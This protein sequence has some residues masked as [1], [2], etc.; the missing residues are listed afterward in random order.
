MIIA[1]I[2][3]A[4]RGERLGAGRPKAFVEVA[5][6]PMFQWSVDAMSGVDGMDRIVLALPPGTRAP[7][8]VIAVDGGA[9]RSDSVRR[10]LAAVEPEG[11]GDVV[12]VHDAARPLVTGELIE[13]VLG[14]LAGDP[15]LDAAIA[16][17][18]VADT[19]KR[20][21][22]APSPPDAGRADR[23]S[24]G[25]GIVVETLDRAGLWAVQT[26]QVF[27]R[28][29]LERA[30]DAPAEVLAQATDDAWL[31]ERLGG[32]V[33]VVAGPAEN[34]KVTTELDLELAELLLTRREQ[35]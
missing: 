3:A 14:V 5:G 25:A 8:G 34:L 29:A 22:P 27:R 6:R 33:A 1:L 26:P 12:V 10:A 11:P 18:P 17:V 4:G 13:A 20:V 24:E 2:V 9:A 7:V 15:S 16:A 28:P 32:R 30:L 35:P 19:V 31:L 23:G 21:A